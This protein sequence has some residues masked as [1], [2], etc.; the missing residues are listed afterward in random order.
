M[1]FG[2]HCDATPYTGGITSGARAEVTALGDEIKRGSAH[3]SLGE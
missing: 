1:R 3:R 2:L